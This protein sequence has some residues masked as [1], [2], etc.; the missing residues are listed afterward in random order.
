MLIN[1]FTFSVFAM[2]EKDPEKSLTEEMTQFSGKEYLASKT[3]SRLSVMVKVWEKDLWLKITQ[4]IILIGT[5][6]GT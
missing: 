3:S 4:C 2:N 5:N 6:H 1:F